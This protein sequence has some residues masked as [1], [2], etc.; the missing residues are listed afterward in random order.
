[1]RPVS[2]FQRLKFL[3]RLVLVLRMYHSSDYYF[4]ARS[5]ALNFFGAVPY[6]L[7]ANEFTSWINF[8]GGQELWDES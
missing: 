1:M 4:E 6:G 3:M 2:S 8:G 5:P 7:T